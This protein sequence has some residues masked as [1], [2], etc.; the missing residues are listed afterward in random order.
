M[1]LLPYRGRAESQM[2]ARQIYPLTVAIDY[3]GEQVKRNMGLAEARERPV[4]LHGIGSGDGMTAIP[5]HM[6]SLASERAART[7]PTSYSIPT[8]G[9]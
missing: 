7:A 2:C 6:L 5:P 9:L 1:Y 4:D 8:V 3:E